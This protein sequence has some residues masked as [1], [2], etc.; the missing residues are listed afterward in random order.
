MKSILVY[1]A[2]CGAGKTTR[3]IDYIKTE[4]RPVIYIA[5]LISET[6]R[7]SGAIVDD[8]EVHMQDD[9]GNY[10]YDQ[11]HPL[12]EKMFRL[13]SN[14]NAYGSKLESLRSMVKYGDNIASTHS[15]FSM[16]DLEIVEH[17]KKNKYVLFVDEALNVWQ[18]FDVYAHL[19]NK[20]CS[21]DLD[22][23]SKSDRVVRNMV[24]NGYIT[25]DD[26][27]LLHWDHTKFVDVQNSL[28]AEVASLCDLKQL[29]MINGKVVVWELNS[30]VLSAFDSVI[31]ATYMFKASF[32]SKY[33]SIHDFDVSIERWGNSPSGIKHLFNLYD[34]NLNDVGDREGV[35]SY[36]STKG[37][38]GKEVAIKVRNSMHNWFLH[39]SKAKANN[40]LWTCFKHNKP[41]ISGRNY[42]GQW[43]AF[44]T[45]AT[46]D[47]AHVENIAYLCNNYPNTFLVQMMSKRGEDFNQ[48]LWAL[49]ELIQWVF[50]SA[51][52]NGNVV[53]MY[54]PSS[55]MRGLLL[56]WL[57]DEFVEV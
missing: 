55:R 30:T 34:G 15:L 28:Y 57:N 41:T 24:D 23:T 10:I 49:S 16:L 7:V 14:R 1:D 48:D 40:R 43:L 17:I 39:H 27:G 36:S 12:A 37:T 31:M 52:R 45:K 3:I 42:G 38:K 2:I 53:N 54:I 44:S 25:V 51:I 26:D 9:L 32:M 13:P 50:R 35:L 22:G 20:K 5:P 19:T 6:V 11:K 47:Y 4:S 33:L 18:K 56:R 8:K 21:D 29:Y 46:N